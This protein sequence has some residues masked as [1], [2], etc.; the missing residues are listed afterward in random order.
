MRNLLFIFCCILSITVAESQSESFLKEKYEGERV[1][2]LIEMPAS[3][4]GI[5]IYADHSRK[6]DFE[7]YSS[8][9]K[10]YGIGLYPGDVIM[11]T[12]IKKKAKHIEFQLAGGGFGTWGDDG[13]NVSADYIPKTSRQEELEKILNEDKDKKLTDRKKLEKELKDLERDRSLRQQESKR[14]AALESEMKKSRIQEQRRQGGSRFNIR[15]DYK[16]G[17]SELTSASIEQALRD[18]VNFTP[19]I[20]SSNVNSASSTDDNNGTMV[21]GMTMEEVMSIMGIPKS[22]TTSVSCELEKT[23]CSF[24]DKRQK[25][26]AIFVEKILVKYTV[27]SM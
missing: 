11:I 26:E 10:K 18:Y 5:D 12:K 1:E 4:E 24:E 25:V 23:V 6:M 22:L 27:S 13:S 16:I 17:N 3:S 15:Y 21:K 8:R 7:D 19:G 20:N 9:I 14:Q 2:V